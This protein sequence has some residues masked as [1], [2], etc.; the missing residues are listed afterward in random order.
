MGL[1]QLLFFSGKRIA[2]RVDLSLFYDE[3]YLLRLLLCHGLIPSSGVT[4]TIIY[5]FSPPFSPVHHVILSQPS[6]RHILHCRFALPPFMHSSFLL[7]PWLCH[8]RCFS[9]I[10]LD[11]CNAPVVPLLCSF[12][13]L[14]FSVAPPMRL[15]QFKVSMGVSKSI[16]LFVHITMHVG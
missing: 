2:L 12:W 3:H 7:I 4:S 16:T 14:A 1:N 13:I 5:H 9:V 11:A 6:N 10:F 8:S 15:W